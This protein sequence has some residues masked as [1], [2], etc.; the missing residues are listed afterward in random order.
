MGT[1]TFDFSD[2]VV[3]ITGSARGI[4]RDIAVGFARAGAHV[5]VSD[6]AG[7]ATAEGIPYKTSTDVDLQETVDAIEATGASA[8]MYPC[9]VTVE[10]EVEAMVDAAVA[11]FGRLDV[12]VNN[13]GVIANAKSWEMTEQQWDVVIDVNLKRRS[14]VRSMLRSI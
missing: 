11:R 4:G 1:T 8:L 2:D 13:A 7:Q 9:D 12:L 14:C 3:L 5:I 10:A 6:L